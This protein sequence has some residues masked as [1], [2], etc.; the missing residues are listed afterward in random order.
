MAE[1]GSNIQAQRS[2]FRIALFGD[3]HLYRL[4]VW[5]WHLLS[6]RVLGQANLWLS[7]RN[8][9]DMSLA[10]EAVHRLETID[11]DLIVCPGD[12]TTTALHGEFRLARRALGELL[13]KYPAF[14]TPG[15]HDRY[16]FTATHTRRFERYFGEHTADRY[17]HHRKLAEGLHLIAIDGCRP[18]LLLDR[19]HVGA[20][21][22]SDLAERLAALDP[23]DQV[24]MVCHYTL[25]V[26]AGHGA[27]GWTHKL[28]DEAALLAVLAESGRS[29]LLVHGHV[30]RPWC[31][32]VQSA[33][34]VVAINAG[35][36][37]H[38]SE[39]L[40]RGQGVWTLQFH[41][42]VVEQ[43]WSVAH[44]VPTEAGGWHTVDVAWPRSAGQRVDVV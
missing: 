25:G 35:S 10:G 14:I 43:P 9:F 42:E 40:P 13:D 12:L 4:R 38:V 24:L 28:V 29:I 39:E 41:G 21:Q 2:K 16:T 33:P 6:K 20:S 44:H 7:R 34:N 17:P 1:S 11:P 26:P 15:N 32:R 18:N 30:H 22:R 37:T 3:I 8:R 23:S 27:E 31:W 5:P 19:G 36:P